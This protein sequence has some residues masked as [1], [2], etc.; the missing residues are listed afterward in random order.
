MTVAGVK[1]VARPQCRVAPISTPGA[2]KITEALDEPRGAVN[3]DDVASDVPPGTPRH[4]R[5]TPEAKQR[6][7]GV[8]AGVG[9][10]E[11]KAV[12]C[13]SWCNP[14]GLGDL[15]YAQAR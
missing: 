12:D 14:R 4:E 1:T 8:P 9:Q 3:P 15:S 11:R 13:R 2:L 10:D 7:G 6:L 5:L